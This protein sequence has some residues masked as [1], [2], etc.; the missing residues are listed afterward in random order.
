MRPGISLDICAS[1]G[2]TYYNLNLVPGTLWTK[3]C[4]APFESLSQMSSEFH[5]VRFLLLP[6]PIVPL[7]GLCSF[8]SR[9]KATRT[10]QEDHR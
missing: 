5:N 2:N 6:G 9:R 10:D 4:M 7:L 3:F 1:Q 8:F